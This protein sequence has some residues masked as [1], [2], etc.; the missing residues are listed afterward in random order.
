MLLLVSCGKKNNT[1]DK[2]IGER[3]IL[4]DRMILVP[5]DADTGFMAKKSNY[6]IIAYFD[7]LGCTPC[8]FSS[9]YQWEGLINFTEYYSDRVSTYLF[10]TPRKS[11][12]H[13]LKEYIKSE[14][15]FNYP[16]LFDNEGE[17]KKINPWLPDG[18]FVCL[19]DSCDIV[20]LAGNPMISNVW[21]DYKTIIK[22]TKY[23]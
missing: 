14:N 20:V 19:I 18:T 1:F 6:K 4:P 10:F 22:T 21:E 17:I 2:Y 23:E 7:S 11:E 16:V 3:F 15:P 9:S 12:Q 5:G 13:S 8:L